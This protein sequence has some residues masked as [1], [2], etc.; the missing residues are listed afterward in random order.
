MQR[1]VNTTMAVYRRWLSSGPLQK[2][3]I[4][5]LE[6]AETSH[7]RVRLDQRVTM[8][9]MQ[10][11]PES[12]RSDMIATRQLHAACALQSSSELS[13][14]RPL[15]QDDDSRGADPSGASQDVLGGG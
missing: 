12:V 10:A 3:H 4:Q 7:N 5:S 2:L 13:T 1:L 11:L 14:R 6:R 9:M 15:R 8:L